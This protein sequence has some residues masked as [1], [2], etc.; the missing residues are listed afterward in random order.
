MDLLRENRAVQLAVYSKLTGGWPPTAYFI[1]N[2]AELVTVHEDVFKGATVIKDKSAEQEVWKV[3]EERTRLRQDE[4]K[5][6]TIHIGIPGKTDPE[7]N[8]FPAPCPYCS[9]GV[10]CKVDLRS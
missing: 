7:E 6:G 1:L 10:F 2:T 5:A 9:Y 4:L 3:I 8:P